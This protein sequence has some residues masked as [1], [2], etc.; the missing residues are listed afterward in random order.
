MYVIR[1][2]FTARPGQASRLAAHFKTLFE[3]LDIK[4]RVLTD[5]IAPFNTVVLETDVA[6]LGAF[7]KAMA[8][9]AARPDIRDKMKGYTELYLTGY[10]EVYKVM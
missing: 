7:E 3:M 1:E 4:A 9:Y 5:H 6:D 8:D 10:R 2:V